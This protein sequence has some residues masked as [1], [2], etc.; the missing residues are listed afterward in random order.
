[1]QTNSSDLRVVKTRQIIKRAFVRLL[2]DRPLSQITVTALA[3][4]AMINRKTFYNHYA[5]LD[6]VLADLEQDIL[7]RLLSALR[8]SN[9]SC[10]EIVPVLRSLGDMIQENKEILIKIVR[11]SPE[12]LQEGR[13]AEMLRRT[14]EVTLR[15]AGLRD[16]FTQR[17]LSLFVVSGVLS[18]YSAWLETGCREPLERL[19][20]AAQRLIYGSLSQFLAPDALN[21]LRLQEIGVPLFS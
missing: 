20:D 7:D 3:E 5:S 17:A 6:E 11:H 12:R 10:L 8:E 9:N 4:E 18:L 21:T 14:M 2:A 1:M 19:V 13:L 15:S 16:P